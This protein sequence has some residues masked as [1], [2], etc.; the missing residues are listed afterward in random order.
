VDARSWTE[1]E[2]DTTTIDH[3]NDLTL[4]EDGDK[5][6]VS[7]RI[8]INEIGSGA[9]MAA[10]GM[11]WGYKQQLDKLETYLSDQEK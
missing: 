10:F 6:V 8:S 7:L 11:K 9:K 4:S 1:G 5:T 3:V 2:Q